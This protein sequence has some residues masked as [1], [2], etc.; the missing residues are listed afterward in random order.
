MPRSAIDR[1][2]RQGYLGALV[3]A[4]HGGLDL[5]MV[6]FGLLNAEAGAACSSLRSIL[7]VHSMVCQ[8]VRRWG[9]RQLQQKWLPRLARGEA[10]GAFALSGLPQFVGIS[11][12]GR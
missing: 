11:G 10:L 7:T 3:S 1:L 4:E 9:S 5:D 12:A 6:S 8:V 2:T